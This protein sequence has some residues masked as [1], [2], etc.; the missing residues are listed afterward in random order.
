MQ[1]SGALRA[2]AADP[3]ATGSP[4][5]SA[6]V[7]LSATKKAP[8]TDGLRIRIPAIGL[9]HA[10]RGEGLSSNGTIDP[11]PDTVMWFTGY[12]R[13]CPGKVGTAVVAAHVAT[14]RRAG[15][16]PTSP[17]STSA[18]PSRCSRTARA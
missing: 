14:G 10:M 11:D 3:V 12:D 15:V 13:V 5:Q 1:G 2:V 4:R 9:D 6:T 8:S 7:T 17:T 16:S 18:T